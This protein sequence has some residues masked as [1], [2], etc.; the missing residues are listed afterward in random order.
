M[1]CKN[2]CEIEDEARGVVVWLIE[3]LRREDGHK[4][5]AAISMTADLLDISP[6]AAWSL[7]YRQPIK[8]TKAFR[9]RLVARRWVLMQ[10]RAAILRRRAD[11]LDQQARAEQS[12]DVVSL[13]YDL[14]LKSSINVENVQ[15]QSVPVT[16][17]SGFGPGDASVGAQMA[18][19]LRGTSQ[20][21]DL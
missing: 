9:D 4:N 1:S 13:Q 8:A 18:A 3:L 15:S 19:S 11:E 10:E 2:I 7:K 12:A 14:P 16:S 17:T 21:A 6:R 20:D 5:E